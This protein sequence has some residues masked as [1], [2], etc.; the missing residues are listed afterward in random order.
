MREYDKTMKIYC[1]NIQIKQMPMKREISEIERLKLEIGM[2]E[3]VLIS[4]I[5]D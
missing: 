5:A 1:M 2:G 3:Y 4:M